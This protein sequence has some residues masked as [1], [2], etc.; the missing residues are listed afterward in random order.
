MLCPAQPCWP[1]SPWASLSSLLLAFLVL[2]FLTTCSGGLKPQ[3][4]G[5]ALLLRWY[6]CPECLGPTKP[7]APCAKAGVMRDDAS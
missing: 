4:E 5:E 2:G 1:V 3:L 7:P 6:E